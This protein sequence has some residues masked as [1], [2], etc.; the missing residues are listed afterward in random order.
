MSRHPQSLLANESEIGKALFAKDWSNTPLGPIK[1]WPQIFRTAL[2][3]C[4]LSDSPASICWGVHQLFFCNDAWR[5]TFRN[6]HP[7][8]FGQGHPARDVLD[9]YW[10]IFEPHFNEVLKSGEIKKVIGQPL[11]LNNGE[12]QT[13]NL[14]FTPLFNEQGNPEGIFSTAKI[15]R[16]NISVENQPHHSEGEFFDFF[17]N[18]PI[19]LHWVAPDGT[20]LKVNQAELDMLGYSREEYVGH[21]ITEFYVDKDRIEDI[22]KRLG[23][24][25][26]IHNYEAQMIRKDGAIV[27]I[28]I[29]SNVFRKDG[30]FIHTRCFTR[31]ITEQK[32]RE[33]RLDE[34]QNRYRTLLNY[35]PK[36][37]VGLF[38]E[39][40]RYTAI[41]GEL[42]SLMGVEP[43]DR[44][45]IK[46]TD[47]YPEEISTEV[48]SY[49]RAA[50]NGETNSFETEF[51]DRHLFVQILP[52][53]SDEGKILAGMVVV[54]DISERWQAQK[55]LRESEAKF[56]MMAENINEVMWMISGD[57]KKFIYINPAFEKVWGIDREKLYNDRFY[58]LDFIHPED[59]DRVRE[60]VTGLPENDFDDEFRIIRPD[61]EV[62]WLHAR[63]SNVIDEEGKIDRI[64]GFTRDI[65]KRK[66]IEQE[67]RNSRNRL[68]AALNID[69]VGV[70]Y[71][72]GED[73]RITEAN[74][75]F[76]KMSGFTHE[77]VI[78]LSWRDLTPEEFH[79]NSEK[80]IADL[81]ETGRT[82]PYEKQYIRKDG[83]RWWGLFA[84]RKIDEEEAV[85]FVLD[86]TD[87]KEAELKNALLSAI[88]EDSDDA[89]ISK[90]LNSI[91]TS[92]NNSAES[93]F[94]YTVEEALGQPITIIFPDDL[95]DEEEEI[96]NKIKRGE[97]LHHYE[98]RRKCKD[99]NFVDISLTISPIRD[100][101]GNIIGASKIARDI[102]KRKEAEEKLE[103]WNKTLEERVEQRTQ[104]LQSYQDQLRSLASQLNKTEERERQRL[105][106]ELHDRLGQMLT[107]A[108]MKVEGLMHSRSGLAPADLEELKE[109][110]DEVLKYNQNLMVELKPPPALNKE[111]ATEV[112][113]WTAKKMRE[114][115]LDIEIVDDAQLQPVEREIQTVLHQSVRELFQ[116]VIKHADTKKA[117]MEITREKGYLKVTV[118]DYGR[119]FVPKE[120][121]LNPTE[122]GRFG[123]FNIKERLDWHG[124]RFEIYSEPGKGTKAVIYAPLKE[125]VPLDEAAKVE[126]EILISSDQKVAPLEQPQ[127]I[128]VILADDHEMVRRGFCR[129]IER[130]GDILIMGEASNG[131]EV[132]ELARK[133]HPDIILM[134]V[135]MPVMG[136]I[137]ATQIIK[138]EMPHIR[139]IGLSLHESEEVA[140]NMQNAGAT[141][142]LKKSE[143]VESLITTIRAESAGLHDSE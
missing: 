16:K 30:E 88:V 81:R 77:E 7:S 13:V 5:N 139:I 103:A 61:G 26:D 65:T 27:E 70:L 48:E 31:D 66:G 99:G 132:V 109:V 117:R 86:I 6:N 64:I 116:N 71:W 35:F 53:E 143:A 52:V 114:K 47:I 104:T 4:L 101:A 72:G 94:G 119:G 8:S 83:T 21:N 123:L 129:I 127:K 9:G 113:Y 40:L 91:I 15:N 124:G 89:I 82:E 1:N 22:L 3:I 120:N 25:A 80:A 32:L 135:N 125:D 142:Y 58:H 85:E 2:Q 121:R 12:G 19:G 49:F 14:S 133:N 138:S 112:L 55:D 24:G 62:R 76:L 79:P 18:A 51:Q 84:P 60:E 57:R 68:R 23:E 69:T 20:I 44:I 36:G 110:V 108:K 107:V 50:L 136:G 45:G 73:L 126:N 10:E 75:A 100:P 102:T 96:I 141:A 87:R 111:D 130:E 134:D 95:L 131:Q 122:G 17:E 43:E 34:S 37:A 28:S 105:A 128:K 67:L 90:D 41:G 29:S 137:E 115:G 97:G 33:R 46:I 118:K 92:W 59:R 54:Q 106:T 74:G 56:R 98:T 42:I 38:D 39:D 140:K 11:A 63:S 93:M 78:G